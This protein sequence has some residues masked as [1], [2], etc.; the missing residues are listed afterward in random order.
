MM[1]R[2]KNLEYNLSQR[3]VEYITWMSETILLKRLTALNENVYNFRDIF[4][5][6]LPFAVTNCDNLIHTL[7]S[8]HVSRKSKEAC[9]HW[10]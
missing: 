3:S 8:R 7:Q 1:D 5:L 6:T 2:E 9:L 4:H 10:I